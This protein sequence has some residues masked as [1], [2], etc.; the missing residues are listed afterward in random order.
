MDANRLPCE[1]GVYCANDDPE[2]LRLLAVKT[3][4]VFAI[5]RQHGTLPGYGKRKYLVIR[6][7]KPRL[8]GFMRGQNIV[9]QGAQSF[10]YGQR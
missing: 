1:I 4:K 5:Q 7:G 8:T 9:P 10:H 3:H 6:D 2:M